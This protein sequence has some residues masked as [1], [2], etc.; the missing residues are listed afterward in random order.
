MLTLSY[1]CLNTVLIVKAFVRSQTKQSASQIQ[2]AHGFIFRLK[3]RLKLM[4]ISRCDDEFV[5]GNR[6]NDKIEGAAARAGFGSV[7]S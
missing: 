5:V 3:H 4:T 6:S 2:P 7:E 1:Q